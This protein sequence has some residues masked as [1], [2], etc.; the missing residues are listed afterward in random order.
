MPGQCSARRAP[1]VLPLQPSRKRLLYPELTRVSHKHRKTDNQG[2]P[3]MVVAPYSLPG[4]I[5]HRV[6]TVDAVTRLSGLEPP[7]LSSDPLQEQDVLPYCKETAGLSEDRSRDQSQFMVGHGSSHLLLERAQVEYQEIAPWYPGRYDNDQGILDT[8]KD[9]RTANSSP[10]LDC[11]GEDF[12]E[13]LDVAADESNTGMMR[14][15]QNTA[16]FDSKNGPNGG[17]SP[18]SSP[19]GS[20]AAIVSD[21]AAHIDE[22]LIAQ[23]SADNARSSLYKPISPHSRPNSSPLSYRVRADDIVLPFPHSSRISTASTIHHDITWE[24]PATPPKDLLLETLSEASPFEQP[25][26]S[27]LID[28]QQDDRAEDADNANDDSPVIN[29]ERRRSLSPSKDTPITSTAAL[30]EGEGTDD[31]WLLAAMESVSLKENNLA[32][33]HVQGILSSTPATKMSPLGSFFSKRSLSIVGFK[34]SLSPLPKLSPRTWCSTRS[35]EMPAPMLTGPIDEELRESRS[36]KYQPTSAPI[37]IPEPR[38]RIEDLLKH[39]SRRDARQDS[40]KEVDVNDKPSARKH[41]TALM[42]AVVQR[43]QNAIY[44]LFKA[45]FVRGTWPTFSTSDGKGDT[46]LTLA[47]NAKF[48]HE[49]NRLLR[50]FVAVACCKCAEDTRPLPL[51]SVCGTLVREVHLPDSELWCVRAGCRWGEKLRSLQWPCLQQGRAQIALEEIDARIEE[52]K[53][54]DDGSSQVQRQRMLNEWIRCEVFNS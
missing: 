32:Y 34:W 29:E 27:N 50:L 46:I 4:A 43:Q 20:N 52:L 6:G 45:A 42:A 23:G 30:G 21:S 11:L 19:A 44:A 39:V 15:V 48:S 14:K 37:Q 16:A 28:H 54:C 25:L 9:I 10:L 38:N 31:Q 7:P 3:G 40:A 49:L 17:T 2:A 26:G 5:E 35:A 47:E 51:G 1:P 13:E 22:L 41:R 12:D 53:A 8:P 33:S 24:I 18:H 36:T